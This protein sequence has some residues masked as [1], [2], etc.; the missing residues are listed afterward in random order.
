ML[1]LLTCQCDIKRWHLF[2]KC[3]NQEGTVLMGRITDLKIE[4]E[5]SILVF[6][7]PFP[8]LA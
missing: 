4:I 6:F 8:V 2:R 1:K 5:T 7:A 3:R